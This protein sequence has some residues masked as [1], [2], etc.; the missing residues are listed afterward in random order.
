MIPRY[1]LEQVFPGNVRAIREF[2]AQSDM[3]ESLARQSSA[4]GT[5]NS[6]D[7]TYITASPNDQLPNERVLTVGEGLSVVDDDGIFRIDTTNELP[8]SGNGF[9][10]IFSSTAPAIILI[11]PTGRM[12]TT[13]NIETLTNKTLTAPKYSGLGDYANDAAAAGGG[14]PIGGSYRNGSVLMVR[15]A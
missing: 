3:V 12:A 6:T 9:Q 5:E 8:K 13:G 1:I 2:E 10:V 14:V 15:V 4:P 7:A 11:P